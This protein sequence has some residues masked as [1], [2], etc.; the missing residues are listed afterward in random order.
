MAPRAERIPYQFRE[1]LLSM[2][3]TRRSDAPPVRIRRRAERRTVNCRGALGRQLADD[4]A[5]L[6]LCLGASSS[7]CTGADA[8]LHREAKPRTVAHFHNTRAD[9]RQSQL[10]VVTSVRG[11]RVR[12]YYRQQ[13]TGM[14]RAGVLDLKQPHRRR[15]AGS[16]LNSYLRVKRPDDPS[17]TAYLAGQL[18]A[19]FVSCR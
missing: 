7:A 1:S 11:S 4:V 13:G 12:F 10:G 14:L 15:R 19:G 16:I 2:D 17:S 9:D 8:A 5:L 6:R 3:D 18:L